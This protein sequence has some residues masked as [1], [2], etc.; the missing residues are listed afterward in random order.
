MLAAEALKARGVLHDSMHGEALRTESV[1]SIARY[2]VDALCTRTLALM[3][4]ANVAITTQ[5]HGVI[6]RVG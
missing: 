5:A 6:H 3:P 4:K 2:M 1:T